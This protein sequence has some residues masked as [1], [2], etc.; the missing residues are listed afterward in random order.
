[1]TCSTMTKRRKRSRPAVESLEG[2]AL[3]TG[4]ALDTTF[5]GTGIVT[6]DFGTSSPPPPAVA[7]QP[8]DGKAVL[9]LNGNSA[10]FE[11]ARYNPDGSLDTTFGKGGLAIA[12]FSGGGQYLAAVAFDPTTH[13][14]YAVG[15]GPGGKM[16]AVARFTPAGTLD[17]TFGKGG[18]VTVSAGRPYTYNAGTAAVVDPSGRLV[19]AGNAITYDSKNYFYPSVGAIYRFTATGALDNT[20]NGTG[21][22]IAPYFD[23]ND[24]WNA[25]QL[26]SSGSSYLIAVAGV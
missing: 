21:K 4:G 10:G 17:P 1:M 13:D 24:G 23:D 12:P 2:R 3:L 22:V 8:W 20:F 19:V 15:S 11:L 14:V 18:E 25:L 7:I 5:G 16:V 6:R 26:E 9:A